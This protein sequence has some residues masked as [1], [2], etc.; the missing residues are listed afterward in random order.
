VTDRA[1]PADVSASRATRKLRLGVIGLG[2]AFMLML[3]GL[4]AHPDY[5]LVAAAD[6]NPEAR[7]RFAAEFGAK[8]YE[9]DAA[10]CRD[11][12]VDAVYVATPH[13]CHA[14]NVQTAAR[15]GKHV[16]VEKPMA[17]TLEDC[18]AM[19]AACA[20]AGA[21]LVVGHSHSFD[22][23]IRRARELISSGEFGEVRLLH[24]FNFTD[25]LYRP[26]RAEE[27]DP[28][29]GG[30][31]IFNQAPHQVDVARLL[32][33]GRTKSVRA[34][35]GAWDAARPVDAAYSALLNFENGAS[36]S[37]TY[38]GFGHFD[39]DEMMSW[40]GESGHAKD[41]ARY[42]E[43]R[44]ALAAAEEG[45][46]RR[47]R[48]YG[49]AAH[50]EPAPVAPRAHPH[51]GPLLVCCERADLRPMPDSI[52]IYGDRE[53]RQELLPPPG[54]PRREVLD[55][56]YDSAILGRPPTQTGEWGLA[57]LEV[58]L[59]IRQSAREGREIELSHQI[60]VGP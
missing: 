23:P 56:F 36:A 37:L 5:A 40:I 28:D 44:R 31:A 41:A 10:L 26:R 14:A 2:R 19:V 52:W 8:I 43:A 21:S 57:T 22:A 49:A 48:G 59:A 18:R 16:L 38:S 12:S 1:M 33:G 6:P 47:S 39:S 24:A 55:A 29:T 25:F 35:A 30:G 32:C 17:L 4:R 46:L 13:Q 58:C 20:A 27:L 50:S 9:D 53:R 51:F 45:A 11:P 60:G 42:G 15:H 3:P 54:I 34:V 7:A